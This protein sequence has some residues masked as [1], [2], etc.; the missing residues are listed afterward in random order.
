MFQQVNP[1]SMPGIGSSTYT[2]GRAIWLGLAGVQ[3]RPGGGLI[4]SNLTRDPDN[5]ETT[6][7]ETEPGVPAVVPNATTS[8]TG[9]LR[10]GL[11]MGKIGGQGG[12]VQDSIGVLGQYRNSILGVATATIASG[13][14]SVTVT[15]QCATEAARIRT[16]VGGNITLKLIGIDSTGALV[17]IAFTAITA[18]SGTTITGTV[19]TISNSPMKVGA[20]ITPADGSQYPVTFTDDQ[21]GLNVVD[22]LGNSVTSNSIAT[23]GTAL[24]SVPFPRIP[25]QGG[26][27]NVANL[28]NYPTGTANNASVLQAWIKASLNSAGGTTTG[29]TNYGG[30]FNFSDD[31]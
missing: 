5:S 13:A 26:T 27:V 8:Y 6:G 22:G 14:S 31:Y 16:L 7:N 29:S 20:F 17:S 15:A 19:G 23:G 24:Y 4:A 25:I 30:R 28:I 11:L 2:R 9:V 21:F 10:A 18:A 1:A 3:Y 12:T